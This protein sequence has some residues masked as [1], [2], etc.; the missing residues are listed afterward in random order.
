MTGAVQPEKPVS[1]RLPEALRGF[2]DLDPDAWYIGPIEECVL[3]GYMSGY[4]ESHFGPSD[5]LTRGQAVCVMANFKRVDLTGYLEP[6]EDVDA[7][8]YYY[9]ALCWALD[10]G[11]VSTASGKFRPGDAVTRSDLLTFLWRMEGEPEPAG[12]PAGF[13]DWKDVPDWAKDAVAWAVEQGVISGAGGKLSPLSV[14]TRA[15][16]CAMITNLL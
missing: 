13:P 16:A 12:E 14:C 10:N 3:Q 9:T 1:E 6:F 11:Y 4:D 15:E 2:T 5:A 7:E 8:P